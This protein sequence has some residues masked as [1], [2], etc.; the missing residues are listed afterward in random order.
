MPKISCSGYC[1]NK[2]FLRISQ[3][4]KCLLLCSWSAR[5]LGLSR[6]LGMQ[7]QGCPLYPPGQPPNLK[8]G[9][10]APKPSQL[11]PMEW[12]YQ[13]AGGK[14]C[15]EAGETWGSTAENATPQEPRS[16]G[17]SPPATTPGHP[18]PKTAQDGRL[19]QVQAMQVG[20]RVLD[21][22]PS[23][24]LPCRGWGGERSSAV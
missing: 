18:K 11:P 13:A 12:N 16:R 8:S 21:A 5:Y 1:L 15:L 23:S 2:T 20:A 14:C 24:Q 3:V 9:W 10:D 4:R 7:K 19:G 17:T 22:Y 6:F